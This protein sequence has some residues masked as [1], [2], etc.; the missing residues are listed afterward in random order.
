MRRIP[1]RFSN[2][3]SRNVSP[4]EYADAPKGDEPLLVMCLG[5]SVEPIKRFLTTCRDFADKQREAFITV[6]ATKDKYHRELWDTTILRPIRPLETVHFDETVRAELVADITNY[7]DPVTRQFYAARGIPYRRGYL[8]HGYPGTGKTS[9]SLALAGMF[10]LELYLVHLPTVPSDLE[11]ERL[12]TALPPRCIVLL[13][14]IDAVGASRMADGNGD[15]DEDEDRAAKARCTL[16]GLLN[17]LDGVS[18]QE[19]RIVLMTS[20]MA[21]KLDSALIRP[22]RIDKMI[23]LGNI[24]HRSAE[25]MFLRMF[26]PDVTQESMSPFISLGTDP[27]ELQKLAIEFGAEL[28]EDTFTPAQLQGYLL[29]HRSAPATAVAALGGWI[30]EE[31]GNMAA[32]KVRAQKVSTYVHQRILLRKDIF[33]QFPF[34]LVPFNNHA[35]YSSPPSH[36]E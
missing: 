33:G 11:L 20:N 36:H 32:A 1:G 25:L 17:V 24:S 29:N 8:L 31:K 5:R 22:G 21:H 30:E 6:R 2:I 26:A 4:A 27:E 3:S 18:S 15:D 13:E 28:P 10:G 12:F 35:P 7:L 34:R 23:F 16:S 9:L 19:G 14:D